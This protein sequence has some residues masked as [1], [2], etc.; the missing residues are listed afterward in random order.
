MS[1]ISRDQVSPQSPF[2]SRVGISFIMYHPTAGSGVIDYVTDLERFTATFNHVRRDLHQLD[3]FRS[4]MHKIL[5]ELYVNR[6]PVDEFFYTIGM[7]F[8]VTFE[9]PVIALRDLS[10]FEMG[11]Q[12]TPDHI[13]SESA[14]ILSTDYETWDS[15]RLD[16]IAA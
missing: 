15:M 8:L 7:H 6:A 16:R 14:F 13:Y 5:M 4:E 10:G 11:F 1:K 9:T 3:A 12:I 2:S